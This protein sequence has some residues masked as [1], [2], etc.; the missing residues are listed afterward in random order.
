M[1]RDLLDTK[2]KNWLIFKILFRA[3]KKRR[4]GKIDFY[5]WAKETNQVNCDMIFHLNYSHLW[6]KQMIDLIASSVSRTVI[7]IEDAFQS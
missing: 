6:E 4:V 3:M 7:V 1:L 2:G 5:S